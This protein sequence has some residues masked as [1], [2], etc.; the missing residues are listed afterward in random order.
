[1]SAKSVPSLPRSADRLAQS[2]DV[3][4]SLAEA[5]EQVQGLVS[6][7]PEPVD[8]L[9]FRD[10]KKYKDRLVGAQSRPAKKTP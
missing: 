7:L 5:A 8:R 4:R 9:K 6:R 10:S 3:S 1:M 2:A